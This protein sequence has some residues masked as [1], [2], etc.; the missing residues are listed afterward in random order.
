[1]SEPENTV[2]PGSNGGGGS[3]VRSDSAQAVEER[4]LEPAEPGGTVCATSD[5]PTYGTDGGS[6]CAHNG[7][8]TGDTEACRGSGSS[9]SASELRVNRI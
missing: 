7:G 9:P 4:G 6:S 2:E 5:S 3:L 8:A 1:M